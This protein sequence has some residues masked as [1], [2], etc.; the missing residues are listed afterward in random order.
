LLG[1]IFDPGAGGDMPL[2]NVRLSPKF[3]D[4]TTKNI[5]LSIDNA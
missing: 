3:Y 1:V 5:V 2:R 4:V